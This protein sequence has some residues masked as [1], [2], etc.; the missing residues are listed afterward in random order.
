MLMTDPQLDALIEEA[1]KE[2]G[3][4]TINDLRRRGIPLSEEQERTV[5]MAIGGAISGTAYGVHGQF[6]AH[7]SRN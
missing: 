3:D 1:T 6:T 7:R 2:T 4:A 5:R